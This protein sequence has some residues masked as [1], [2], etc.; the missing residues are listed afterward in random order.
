LKEK[1]TGIQ[2]V[3]IGMAFFSAGILSLV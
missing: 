1:L 3:G 2:F